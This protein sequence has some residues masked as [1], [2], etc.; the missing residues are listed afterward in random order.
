MKRA[1]LLGLMLCLTAAAACAA[2]S[3]SELEQPGRIELSAEDGAQQAPVEDAVYTSRALAGQY[4]G[5]AVRVIALAEQTFEEAGT[6]GHTIA[7]DIP[8]VQEIFTGTRAAEAEQEDDLSGL[9]QLTYMQDFKRESTG[10]RI[11]RG[12]DGQGTIVATIEGG[13]LVRAARREDFVIVQLNLET[14]E[15]HLLTMREYDPETG[16]FTAAFPCFGPYMITI[17]MEA[18]SRQGA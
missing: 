18:V 4:D 15:R 11:E 14:G 1:I 10:W 12:A 13:E 8:S 5:D 2:P 7:Q 16:V 6:N 17:R 9:K 3:I